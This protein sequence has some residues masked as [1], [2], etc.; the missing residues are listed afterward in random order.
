VSNRYLRFVIA[1]LALVATGAAGYRIVEHEQRL[2]TS[3]AA[4]RGVAEIAVSAQTSI[5][6]I[7]AALHAYVAPGQG[8][9]FWATR[10]STLID[11]LR[12]TL[13]ELDQM[14]SSIE[15]VSLAEALD[16][17]DRLASSERRARQHVRAG[18]A[19]LAGDVIFVELR[20]LTETLRQQVLGAR[21][22]LAQAAD[23]QHA[24]IRREQ[25]MLMLGSAGILGLAIL[26]LLPLGRARDHVQAE[27]MAASAAATVALGAP[28]DQADAANR[29]AVVAP[30]VAAAPA[31]APGGTARA[32]SVTDRGVAASSGARAQVQTPDRSPAVA[33]APTTALAEAA[34]VCT[35][36][37][38]VSD[39]EEI[40]AL[41]G[42]AADVLHATGI[43]VWM[44]TADQRALVPAVSAGYDER[45][46]TR[47]PSIEKD[48]ANLTAA[49]FREAR[50][51]TSSRTATSAA[52]LA[53]PLLTS[54]GAVG[55]LSAELRDA[56]EIDEQRLALARIFTAQLSILLGAAVAEPMVAAEEPAPEAA[57]Q[58]A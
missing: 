15:G 27:P 7:T 29:H 39:S 2:A 52:A 11:R 28:D 58:E 8:Q 22:Q 20:D 50:A 44:A 26:L 4:S 13:L 54:E 47:I 24:L 34:A 21:D 53:V 1:L 33:S 56:S 35:D 48:A 3:V 30:A 38:R 16:L 25:V 31:Q 42:R 9:E 12:S 46:F 19:L 40:S 36:L 51:Q 23:A 57:A 43:I 41:L 49:A 32:A 37:A 45:L 18:Q 10:A 55:V 6:E 14:A 5:L 17:S